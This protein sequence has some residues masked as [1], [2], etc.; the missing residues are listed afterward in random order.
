MGWLGH[1]DIRAKDGTRLAWF[2]AKD[3]ESPKGDVLLVHGFAD[4][5]GRYPHVADALVAA[6]WR[7]RGIDLRG[8]G[9][10]D[11]KRGFVRRWSDY[12]DDLLAAI[13]RSPT[14]PFVL[15]HSM[16]GL[17]LLDLLREHRVR[18]AIVCS[19]LLR[20]IVAAPKWKTASAH[21]LSRILPSLSLG[22][23]LHPENVSR[24]PATQ[25][26]YGS[27]PLVFHSATPRWYT[28]MLD[29]QKRVIASAAR[30]TTPALFMVGMGEKI[31]DP[32]PVEQMAREWGG[33]AELR[34]WDGLYHEL[35]NEPERAEV[36]AHVATWLGK[37]S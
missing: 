29:A 7:V 6:G 15:A 21:V 23:E 5:M 18:G 2:K 19:P 9:V 37:A 11:G 17:A 4:H 14:E 1:E 35:L 27:D 30:Q 26:A 25:K 31:V 10:S 16:G 8:H 32:A 13:A 22:N 3:P 24:D 36:L 33:P 12:G 28:E 34:K 20:A